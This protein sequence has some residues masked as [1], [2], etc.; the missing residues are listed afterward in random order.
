MT[1]EIW[2]AESGNLLATHASEAAAACDIHETAARLGPDS[3]AHFAL[4]FEDDEGQTHAIA[5]GASL[6]RWAES[7]LPRDAV[8][9]AS[10]SKRMA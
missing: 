5:K 2:D 10:Q 9:A 7:V 1:F 6:I 3:L 4:A 8:D